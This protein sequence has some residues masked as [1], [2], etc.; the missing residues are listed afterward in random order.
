MLRI[1]KVTEQSPQDIL[2]KATDFFG[3][4][5]TGLTVIPHGPNSVE[6]TGGGGFVRVQ[7]EPKERG[8]E[9][10][11]QTQEWDYDAKRFLKQV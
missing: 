4:N 9:I 7:V 3:P 6:F 11:V 8:T 5:G 1:G 10:D 2:A